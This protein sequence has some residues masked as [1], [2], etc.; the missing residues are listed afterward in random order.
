LFSGNPHELTFEERSRGGTKS[1]AQFTFEER[2]RGGTKSAA[3]FTF[4][5]RS[6][7]GS[8]CGGIKGKGGGNKEGSGIGKH[9]API[10]T[11]AQTQA[12]FVSYQ[13]ARP[14]TLPEEARE[15][16]VHERNRQ[17]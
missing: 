3:Q 12:N 16:G 11:T 4:D 15:N 1:A 14:E 7:G 6:R 10:T 5:D 17:E 2:S 9:S 8:A 13:A